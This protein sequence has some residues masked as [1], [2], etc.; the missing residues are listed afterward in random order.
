MATFI[1]LYD[2]SNDDA[3]GY[4]PYIPG[5]GLVVDAAGN[6]IGT[7][8]RGG[9][10]NAGAVFEIPYLGGGAYGTAT[11]LLAFPTQQ[12]GPTHPDGSDPAGTLFIDAS[13]NL[14]GTAQS[15]G[16]NGQG[17]VY[18]I[19]NTANGYVAAASP[20]VSFSSNVSGALP[21]APYGPDTGLVADSAGNLFGVTTGGGYLDADN[22]QMGTVYEIKHNADGSYASTPTVIA[23]FTGGDGEMP[24]SSLIVDKN[25]D[26]FGTTIE[27]GTSKTNGVS[28]NDGVVFEIAHNAD[29]SY[30]APV[31]LAD[32]TGP[33]GSPTPG[34]QPRGQLAMDAAGDLFGTTTDG[35]D[36][37]NDG[38]VFEI[39]YSNGSYQPLRTLVAFNSTDG[40]SPIGGLLVD[41]AGNLFGATS[42]GGANGFGTVFEITAAS[43]YSQ[44]ITV[45]NFTGP[46]GAAPGHFDESTLSVDAAGNL[47]GVTR[48]GGA[49]GDGN[50]FEITD[51]GFQV[52]CY[53]SGTLIEVT[54]G[55]QR[56]VENLKIGDKVRTASGALRPIKWIG[57]RSYAGRFIRG[58]K[59]ILPVCFKA[60]SLG[61]NVPERDLRISPQH[62]MY[63]ATANQGGMLVEAKDLINGVSIVQDEAAE[64]VDYFHIELDSHDVIVAEGALSETFIDDDS[65]GMFHNAREYET[66]YADV[67]Q[68][69]SYCAPRLNEGYEIEAVR[70]RLAQ[71][72]GLL[73]SS[74]TPRLGA[75]RGYVD[76]I[77]ASSIAGWA[78]SNDAPE[79][80]VC[81]DIF[82]HGKLIGRVL[83]N[84]YRKDLERAGLGSGRHAFTFTPPGGLD[85]TPEAVEVRRS[86]DQTSLARSNAGRTSAAA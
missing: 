63:F 14:I 45:V 36:S 7:T 77:R 76:R 9:A 24:E 6:L 46:T 66:L 50:V 38:T 4:L 83:A 22:F 1:D 30:S 61:D 75:L 59:D 62:A 44:L 21:F 84:A 72:A 3:V 23:D 40:R 51:S 79:A 25:G 5:G 12:S 17:V 64:R 48:T 58:R 27:G 35:G 18:E 28:N 43:G 29:G 67:G 54:R 34:E 31:T 53:C 68:P 86:A 74:G 85:L 78:Q 60:G 33:T 42:S 15:G 82:I 73:P 32:F 55:R 81:L 39:A 19:T 41:A 2:F 80:P 47:F 57:R 11:P 10:G 26:L 69:A 70:A 16:A 56:K 49:N 52:A 71:R 8:E 65:R 13:G 20:L 37:N